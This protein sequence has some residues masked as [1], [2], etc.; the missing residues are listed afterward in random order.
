MY[1]QF[2]AS[3]YPLFHFPTGNTDDSSNYVPRDAR[4][5]YLGEPGLESP[6]D[7]VEHHIQEDYAGSTEHMIV[8]TLD[9]RDHGNHASRASVGD[10]AIKVSSR[11]EARSWLYTLDKDVMILQAPLYRSWYILQAKPGVGVAIK[12]HCSLYHTLCIT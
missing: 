7:S 10:D 2:L 9:Q 4:P 8:E 6:L 11:L 5:E 3:H 12:G 1:L